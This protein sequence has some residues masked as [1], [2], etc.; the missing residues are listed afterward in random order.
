[1]QLGVAGLQNPTD[2]FAEGDEL[3]MEITEV[4]PDNRRIV[5]NTT[6][7]PKLEEGGVILP[8]SAPAP[9]AEESSEAAA[10]APEVD[11]AAEA[12]PVA[13]AEAEAEAPVEEDTV[14]VAAATGGDEDEV[15]E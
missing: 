14:E 5:L 1:S 9:E 15:S 4:D 6:R 10:E 11:A 2:L 13:E 7:V 3:E 12:A 8:A